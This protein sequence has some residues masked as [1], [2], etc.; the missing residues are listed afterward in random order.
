METTYVA[1]SGRTDRAVECI[2]NR[3][4]FS[5][6]KKKEIQSF[7]SLWAMFTL[8]SEGHLCPGLSKSLPTKEPPLQT[9]SW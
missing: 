4:L 6:E 3:I 1:A 2:H 7:A 9:P 8:L 5:H